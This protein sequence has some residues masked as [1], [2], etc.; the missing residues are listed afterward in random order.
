MIWKGVGRTFYFLP[1]DKEKSS[2]E[3]LFLER[4]WL[5]VFLSSPLLLFP[6]RLK[7]YKAKNGFG[8]PANNKILHFSPFPYFLLKKNNTSLERSVCNILDKSLS[9]LILW[10]LLYHQFLF[11]Q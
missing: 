7:L 4:G 2:I 9:K 6:L 10:L 5:T 8:F 3:K 1:Q 11:C